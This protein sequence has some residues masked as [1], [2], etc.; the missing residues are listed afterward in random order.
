MGV[1]LEAPDVGAEFSGA[2]DPRSAGWVIE[3]DELVVVADFL[4]AA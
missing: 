4:D 1:V 2:V 3:V